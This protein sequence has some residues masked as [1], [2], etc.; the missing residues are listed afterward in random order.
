MDPVVESTSSAPNTASPETATC[1]EARVEPVAMQETNT[2]PHRSWQHRQTPEHLRRWSWLLISLAA[3]GI[4]LAAFSW[5]LLQ[6]FDE[7]QTRL[8]LISTKSLGGNSSD[9]LLNRVPTLLQRPLEEVFASLTHS[10]DG[11]P[12]APSDVIAPTS[13]S[14]LLPMIRSSLSSETHSEHDQILCLTELSPVYREGA[15]CLSGG[16]DPADPE[17][18]QIRFRDFVKAVS[19]STPARVTVFLD[20]QQTI[21]DAR[22]GSFGAEYPSVRNL[23]LE[24]ISDLPNVRVMLAHDQN[25]LDQSHPTGEPLAFGEIVAAGLQGAADTNEDQTIDLK[26]LLTYAG[27]FR[28]V[29][30]LNSQGREAISSHNEILLPVSSSTSLAAQGE[31]EPNSEAVKLSWKSPLSKAEESSEVKSRPLTEMTPEELLLKCWQV[32]EELASTIDD[33]P[34]HRSLPMSRLAPMTWRRFGQKLIGCELTVARSNPNLNEPL[35]VW[36]ASRLG[37]LTTLQKQ[38]SN[39]PLSSEWARRFDCTIGTELAWTHQTWPLALQES[40]RV[41]SSH[42]PSTELREARQL[43]GQF[44]QDD[45]GKLLAETTFDQKQIKQF[46]EF[47]FV[48]RLKRKTE[49]EEDLKQ[50][51]IES[52][53]LSERLAASGEAVTWFAEDIMTADRLRV[54]GDRLIASDSKPSSQKMARERYRESIAQYKS[55]VTLTQRVIAAYEM[56]DATLERL[57]AYRDLLNRVDQVKGPLPQRDEAFLELIDALQSILVTLHTTDSSQIVELGRCCRRVESAETRLRQLIGFKSELDDQLSFGT[58]QLQVDLLPT[59]GRRN[60]WEQR[61]AAHKLSQSRLSETPP[62]ASMRVVHS[63]LPSASMDALL[64]RVRREV[65]LARLLQPVSSLN[66]EPHSGP[67]HLMGHLKRVELALANWQ[68]SV[69]T[70]SEEMFRQRLDQLADHLVSCYALVPTLLKSCKAGDEANFVHLLTLIDV[71]D[72]VPDSVEAMTKQLRRKS[73]ERILRFQLRRRS[74]FE[75]DATAQERTQLRRE[76]QELALALQRLDPTMSGLLPDRELE[77]TIHV[78]YSNRE[79]TTDVTW[80][81]EFRNCSSHQLPIWI[82]MSELPREVRYSLSPQ[83]TVNFVEPAAETLP[84]SPCETRQSKQ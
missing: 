21:I 12:L 6:P 68:S 78:D 73:W 72:Q 16:I 60:L 27:R 62:S 69:D 58:D 66:G 4:S 17:M 14:D 57:T 70:S 84:F 55:I 48:N 20:T 44:A 79:S 7:P 26:E 28:A 46:A 24:S 42:F 80:R 41:L 50:L 71:R 5:V 74:C 51:A 2:P 56:R 35:R 37:D 40:A 47:E 81:L 25:I 31:A 22:T 13:L 3:M 52:H 18:G 39:S 1:A 45:T 38:D 77:Y 36:L 49:L 54:R 11:S 19:E 8:L 59:D 63:E 10:S 23:I 15:F 61:L 83:L 76:Q 33:A 67:D 43:L 64:H 53:V 30:L 34:L 75:S 82:W 65:A 32:R 29:E 9:D